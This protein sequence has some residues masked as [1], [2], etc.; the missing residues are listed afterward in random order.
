MRRRTS[1]D[2]VGELRHSCSLDH[3]CS[4][5]F[6]WKPRATRNRGGRGSGIRAQRARARAFWVCAARSSTRQGARG[7]F[8]ADLAAAREAT[9]ISK[10]LEAAGAKKS[11][12]KR[13]VSVR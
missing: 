4:D 13:L 9:Q 11:A 3:R 10:M 1:F 5:S 2:H 12:P 6:P 8:P 7:K